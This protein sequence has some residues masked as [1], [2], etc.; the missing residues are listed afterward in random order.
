[1]KKI[2]LILFLLFNCFSLSYGLIIESNNILDIEEIIEDFSEEYPLVEKNNVVEGLFYLEIIE[3]N[4]YDTTYVYK[5]YLHNTVIQIDFFIVNEFTKTYSYR[6][7][8]Y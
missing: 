4:C 7:K 1:M 3:V 8:V 5:D 6:I 2:I